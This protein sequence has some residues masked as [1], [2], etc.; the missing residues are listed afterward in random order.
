MATLLT[1]LGLMPPPPQEQTR[2]AGS[3][4]LASAA[5]GEL[6]PDSFWSNTSAKNGSAVG[7][8]PSPVRW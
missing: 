7:L 4:Y 6:L 1:Q 3:S 8:E 5:W 2:L